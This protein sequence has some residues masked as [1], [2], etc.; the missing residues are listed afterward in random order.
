MVNIATIIKIKD[1]STN[2]TIDRL[3]TSMPLID[4]IKVIGLWN[5]RRDYKDYTPREYEKY[6]GNISDIR[7]I[8]IY[9]DKNG[10]AFLGNGKFVLSQHIIL[11][12]EPLFDHPWYAV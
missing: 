1:F 11:D 7:R 2:K 5:E 6:N 9:F 4:A 12:A 10:Y 8:Q 3:G